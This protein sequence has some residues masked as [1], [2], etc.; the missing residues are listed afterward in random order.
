MNNDLL[1]K[2]I[3]SRSLMGNPKLIDE[4]V[5]H[6]PKN[7]QH[8]DLVHFMTQY[9]DEYWEN[10]HI[11]KRKLREGDQISLSA[12]PYQWIGD[13][14]FTGL[15]NRTHAVL[16]EK[17]NEKNFKKLILDLSSGEITYSK[18]IN[19]LGR[20]FINALYEANF[21]FKIGNQ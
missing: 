3:S 9:I 4:L 20:I 13:D 5:R 15:K 11:S 1:R 16:I 14:S 17:I 18:K 6:L 12:I 21:I 2:D 10:F 8:L 7:I 19:R